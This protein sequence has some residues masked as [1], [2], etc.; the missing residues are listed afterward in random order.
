MKCYPQRRVPVMLSSPHEAK[1]PFHIDWTIIDGSSRDP[2]LWALELKLRGVRNRMIREDL[3]EGCAVFYT[4]TGD[5]MWPLVQSYDACTFHPIQAVTA[6]DGIHSIHSFPK[7]ASEIQVG[8]VVF[9]KV[10]RSDSYFAHLVLRIEW[11]R[12]DR[13]GEPRYVIGN[14]LQ[15]VNGWCHRRHI[16]G[17]LV[18]VQK[19]C[20][21]EKCYYSRPLP[22][23]VYDQVRP[24]VSRGRENRWNREAAKLCEPRRNAPMMVD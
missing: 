4:S 18:D 24:L 17:I 14:I 9:C 11:P 20:P 7:E 21:K 10:Q 19:W 13:I 1:P 8:D 5:S 2:E 6:E 16:F 3:E 23:T 12:Y 22:R 15:H